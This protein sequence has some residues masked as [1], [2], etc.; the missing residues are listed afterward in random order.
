EIMLDIFRRIADESMLTR[1][2]GL[3]CRNWHD[4]LASDRLIPREIV[5]RSDC[6]LRYHLYF[7]RYHCV[8]SARELAK[9]LECIGD[10]HF[11]FRINMGGPMPPE[12]WDLVPWHRFAVQ[13]IGLHLSGVSRK[14][15]PSLATILTRLPP[16]QSLRHLTSSGDSLVHP[17]SFPTNTRPALL[18]ILG[19]RSLTWM[20]KGDLATTMEP[21]RY[22]FT[23]ITTLK[24][25]HPGANISTTLLV[26]MF[27]SCTKLER[28]AWIAPRCHPKTLEAIRN[29]VNWQFQLQELRITYGLLPAFPPLVLSRLTSLSE[30]LY[31]G[32]GQVPIDGST[33]TEDDRLHLPRLRELTVM[34]L[35]PQVVKIEDRRNGGAIEAFLARAPI[36]NLIELQMN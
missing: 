15:Y 21:V 18:P 34:S 16:L 11:H 2:V 30:R 13:C 1:D 23:N 8:H 28:L 31:P 35:T 4:L 6:H 12:A 29:G 3:T 19:L 20:P 26:E 27:S 10:A 14:L 33:G 22:L 36:V 9:A 24:L 32:T 7:E 17:C 5:W 25:L